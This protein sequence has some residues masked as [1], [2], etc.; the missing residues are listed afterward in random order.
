V[1]EGSE[2]CEECERGERGE[3]GKKTRFAGV[4]PGS[5]YLSL[6]RKSTLPS[7]VAMAVKSDC[8]NLPVIQKT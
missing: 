3:K 7:Q 8:A 2:E 5:L 1:S 6:R 4:L